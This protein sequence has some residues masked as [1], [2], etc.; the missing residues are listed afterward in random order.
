MIYKI[1]VSIDINCAIYYRGMRIIRSLFFMLLM[2]QDS[3]SVSRSSTSTSSVTYSSVSTASITLKPR[4]TNTASPTRTTTESSTASPTASPTRTTT[5]SST[6]SPTAS[7]TLLPI[8]PVQ[9]SSGSTDLSLAGSIGISVVGIL[10]GGTLLIVIYY[11]LI[12]NLPTIIKNLKTRIKAKIQETEA[13]VKAKI[14]ETEAQVQ[15]LTQQLPPN[16]NILINTVS[17]EHT[18]QNI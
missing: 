3:E 2:L 6:A 13:Q 9:P 11:K 1:I 15:Q 17:N 10:T 7:L 8:V 4:N 12:K 14:Q 5:G 18:I 16:V